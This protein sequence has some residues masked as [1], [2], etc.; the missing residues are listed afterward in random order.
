MEAGGTIP[1]RES[2][3]S[4][5][6]RRPR[7]MSGTYC[8]AIICQNGRRAGRTSAVKAWKAETARFPCAGLNH[9]GHFLNE[10]NLF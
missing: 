5:L 7:L 9:P 1:W 6:E 4:S 2:V 8:R 3:E 10:A